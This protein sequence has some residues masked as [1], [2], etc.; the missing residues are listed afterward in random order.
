VAYKISQ[1]EE[2]EEEEIAISQYRNFK[3]TNKDAQ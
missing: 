3:K 2:E 1:E